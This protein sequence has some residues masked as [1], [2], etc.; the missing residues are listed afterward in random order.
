MTG[1]PDFDLTL[2]LVIGGD[3]TGGRRVEDVAAAAVAGGVTLVQ[4]REKTLPDGELVE[5]ARALKARLT[6]LGVPLIIN[7][8]ASVA[9]E[10]GADGVHLGQEDLDAARAREI[11]GPDKLIGVSAGT[12]AEAGRV[13]KALADYVG[14]GPVY[15]TPTKPDAGPPIGIAGLLAL[16]AT[17]RPLPLVA[18]GGIG[19]DNAAEVMAS[20]AANGIAVVSAICGADDPEAAAR[21]LRREIE[22]GQATRGT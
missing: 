20:G 11:L 14:V 13:D 5:R 1:K 21:D 3:V 12:R 18:I 2:Y 9:A 15:A 19:A 22:T 8:R 10:A 6:P 16:G 7:D 17:L 4:L